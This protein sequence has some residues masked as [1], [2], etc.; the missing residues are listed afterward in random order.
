MNYVL[1]VED[2]PAIRSILSQTLADEGYDVRTA[3][4]GRGAL[5]QIAASPPGL[6]V[7]DL[8]MPVMDGFQF[9]RSLPA[10]T[11][12]PPPVLVLSAIYPQHASLAEIT[13]Y[14]FLPKPFDLDDLLL[15]VHNLGRSLTRGRSLRLRPALSLDVPVVEDP[16]EKPPRSNGE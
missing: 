6:I 2:D 9:L 1:I 11:A 15:K 13:Q 8:M 3:S 14:D 16:K 5:A 12:V 10:A 4:D 7:L